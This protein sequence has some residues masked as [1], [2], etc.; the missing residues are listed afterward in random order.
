MKKAIIVI[1][2]T[3]IY[4]PSISNG[5]TLPIPTKHFPY[6]NMQVVL[7]NLLKNEVFEYNLRSVEESLNAECNRPEVSHPPFT[8][9]RVSLYCINNEHE[10]FM[11]KMNFKCKNECIF[12]N[13]L[14]Y[15]TRLI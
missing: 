11:L 2:L 10:A 6:E 7:R 3:I 13:Y 14:G 8:G 5:Q 1:L 15:S 9:Y 4:Y 12:A